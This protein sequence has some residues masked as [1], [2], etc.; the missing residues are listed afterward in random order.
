MTKSC[1]LEDSARAT[2][3]FSFVC[4]S[5]FTN[6]K[7]SVTCQGNRSNVVIVREPFQY[8]LNYI[9]FKHEWMNNNPYIY[10]YIYI[11]IYIRI[12]II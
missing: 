5:F 9:F 2:L 6:L 12:C 3:F 1:A 11:Y 8:T 10:K 7:A 4:L